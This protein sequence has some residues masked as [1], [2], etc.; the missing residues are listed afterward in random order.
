MFAYSL[1]IHDAAGQSSLRLGYDP[2]DPGA[3]RL[4]SA[5]D[6]EGITL[7]TTFTSA[8]L[9]YYGA[10][11]NDGVDSWRPE[12]PANAEL[13]P[14]MVRIQFG[15]NADDSAWPDLILPLRSRPVN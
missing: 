5:F 3:D 2:Y 6:G 4:A 15:A 14:K 12:W 13:F 10:V 9:A 1:V 7:A 11:S 8:S